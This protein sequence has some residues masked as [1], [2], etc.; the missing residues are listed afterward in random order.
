MD[1]I[2]EHK[3]V[4]HNKLDGRRFWSGIILKSQSVWLL[5][6]FSSSSHIK[7][8]FYSLF[9]S[10]PLLI[11]MSLCGFRS[12][13]VPHHL[14]A[15]SHWHCLGWPHHI[16]GMS[17]ILLDQCE[18]TKLTSWGGAPQLP[19]NSG[20]VRLWYE[21]NPTS[22]RPKC[23]ERC[24]RLS[25]MKRSNTLFTRTRSA[26]KGAEKAELSQTSETLLAHSE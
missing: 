14:K 24:A 12:Y 15:F 11:L 7:I 9:T 25:C 5:T 26:F 10:F 8:L 3:A 21:H 16:L 19:A 18:Y 20:A 1:Y 2:L 13:F 22:I 17:V 6:E 4:K 23:N